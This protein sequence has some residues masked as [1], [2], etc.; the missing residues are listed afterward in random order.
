MSL[1]GRYYDGRTARCE[2]I[3]LTLGDDDLLRP[4][5]PLFE[6]QAFGNVRISSRIGNTSRIITLSSGAVIESDD[7]AI[8][9]AW[10]ARR[11]KTANLMH[12]FE[13]RFSYALGALGC[14]IV[15]I[16]AGAIWGVPGIGKLVA[17]AVPAAAVAQLGTQTLNT[18]DKGILRPSELNAARRTELTRRFNMLLPEDADSLN[19]NLVFRGGAFIG[20]N[21]FALPDGTIVIT[22]KL[23]ELAK[24]D[25]EIAAVL[26][27]EIGHVVHRHGLRLII[28][29]AGLS[30]LMIAF[31]GDVTAAG[32]LL[33]ALPSI[34]MESRYSRD[35]EWEAD[36]YALQRMQQ[37]GL[38]TRSFADFLE[39][40]EGT[41]GAHPRRKAGDEILV[42]ELP[43]EEAEIEPDEPVW[44]SYISAHPPT[45]ARIARFRTAAQENT[46]NQSANE[47]Q[48][49][50]SP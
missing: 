39:R 38:P 49:V 1:R 7:H 25:D 10:T 3:R 18:L 29:H 40:M 50:D 26:L 2:T 33:I 30:T 43:T 44:F 8:L 21:A 41:L 24:N 4:D 37:E 45:T 48:A 14:V 34:L 22:D 15:I 16:G 5:P 47:H 9:D 6:P 19:Y 35:L 12:H 46:A 42:E 23:V 20:A 31:T 28:S 27:H 17:H 32:T 36:G 11:S 13:S